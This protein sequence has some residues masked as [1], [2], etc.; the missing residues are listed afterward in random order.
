MCTSLLLLHCYRD[1][2]LHYPLPARP[3]VKWTRQIVQDTSSDQLTPTGAT[4]K[5][6]FDHIYNTLRRSIIWVHD[7]EGYA[8]K[9]NI[10]SK[11]SWIIHTYHYYQVNWM[12]KSAGPGWCVNSKQPLA[13]TETT[14]FYP[15]GPITWVL[16]SQP[17]T[18]STTLQ[19]FPRVRNDNKWW[20][21]SPQIKQHR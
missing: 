1:S 16:I 5:R 19:V 18:Q 11:H 15:A 4:C 13:R 20:T 9:A 17:L 3:W 10:E 14:D 21:P 7:A 6:P 8:L 12:F 2:P